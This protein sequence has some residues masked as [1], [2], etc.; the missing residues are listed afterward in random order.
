[1]HNCAAT[2][3]D[4]ADVPR[5]FNQIND[6]QLKKVLKQYDTDPHEFKE[7]F[8]GS[9]V[10]KFDVKSGDDGDLYLVSKDGKVVI[11]TGYSVSAD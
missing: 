6:K 8:V 2:A 11:P 9:G 4:A 1:M 7:W 5:S 10:S 3:G